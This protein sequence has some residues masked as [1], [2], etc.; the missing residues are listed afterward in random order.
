MRF[1]LYRLNRRIGERLCLRGYRD[2]EVGGHV[3]W[4]AGAFLLVRRTAFDAVGGFDERQW[5]YAEDLDLAWR[6]ARAGWRTRYEPRAIVHHE[7]SAA[8]RKVWGDALRQKWIRATY[9]WVARRRGLAAAR[10]LAAFQVAMSV[11]DYAAYSLLAVVSDSPRWARRKASARRGIG[12]H[13]L[14][15]RP[16]DELLR[17]R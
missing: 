14:G 13:R 1:R 10:S 15:L 9:A 16:R 7:E 3:D 12:L 11:M 6:L 17:D 4:A 5:L 2:P 8:T